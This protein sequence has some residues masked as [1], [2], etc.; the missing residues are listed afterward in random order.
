V[1]NTKKYCV[2]ALVALLAGVAG[3]HAQSPTANSFSNQNLIG[4]YAA[5]EHGDGSVSVGMGIVRYDGN[6]GATRRITVNAPGEDG[7][8]RILVFESDGTYMVNP[9]GTGAVTFTNTTAPGET[10]TDTF[11]FVITGVATAW[12]PGPG[13]LRVAK[14]LFAAQ[15]EAGV[16]VSLVTSKQKRIAN[17]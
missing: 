17:E 14:E 12:I 1:T 10:T 5:E 4:S 8:R 13:N 6:G 9:D 11:D 3:L 16:T 15:R 7:A 2:A